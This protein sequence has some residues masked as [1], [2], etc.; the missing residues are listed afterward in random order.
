M[1]MPLVGLIQGKDLT[2]WKYV[3]KAAEGESAEVSL[4]YGTFL[5]VTIE[6]IIV[7][8]VMFMVVKAIN[9]M[10]KAQPAPA[11]AGPTT[12]QVLLTEIRDL[13]KK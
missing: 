8:F 12:D 13:L 2:E 10:K 5:T 3:M 6:F 9:K 7:A 4:K 11:P 1:V